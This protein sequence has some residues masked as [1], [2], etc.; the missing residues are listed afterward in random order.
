[1]SIAQN[2]HDNAFTE[3]ERHEFSAVAIKL[4]KLGVEHSQYDHHVFQAF[5]L[6]QSDQMAQA[7]AL[8]PKI[9]AEEE[10]LDHA[11]EAMLI[12]V[13][14][15]TDHAAK[16]AE[17]HEKFA[18]NLMIAISSLALILGLVFS[19]FL[20]RRSISRP[21]A[22]VT[23]GLDALNAD[24]LSV[25][26]RVYNHDEIGA[27]AKAYAVFKATVIRTKNLEA[28]QE[29]QM[30]RAEDEKRAMMSQLADDFDANVG[31]IV[32][33]VS[34]ASTELSSTA[35]S[36]AG[37]SEETSNRANSVAAASEQA[38][39]NVQTVA[40]AAEEMSASIAEINAQVVQASEVSKTAVINVKRTA[41]QMKALSDTANK[42]GEV[43]SMIS[44]IAEQTNLLALNATIESARAGEAGKGFAVVATEVKALAGETARATEDISCLV[45]D[46]QS[47]TGEAVISIDEIGS[48][49]NQLEGSSTAIAAAM[50]EQ[51]VTTQEVA[52]NVSEAAEGTQ[53]VTLNIENVTQASREVGAASGEV[54][55][56]AGEL[57]RQSEMLKSEIGGFISHV[58]ARCSPS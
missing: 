14:A 28:E 25:D 30:Q 24:D 54:T 10:D 8:L 50:E 51:G 37:I 48:I 16:T 20:V 7:M 33:T 49:I 56:A 2:A 44:D 12:D 21:L 34:A 29:L 18:L 41:G 13:E 22:D 46:I 17:A 23:A 39:T 36:M 58:R 43:I 27:V 52:R 53:D 6:I 26:V 31:S 55:S 9:E 4:D 11:L 42:I 38:S 32:E 3:G 1:M 35:Q 57:S 47:A 45:Q 40:S 5:D 15:F 19:V